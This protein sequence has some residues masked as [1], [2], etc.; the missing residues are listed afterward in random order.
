MTD[1]T[2][3]LADYK[4]HV[5]N[6]E[7]KVILVCRDRFKESG[8]TEDFYSE[9]WE[10]LPVKRPKHSN[11]KQQI[12]KPEELEQMIELAGVLSKAIP[13]VRVDFY[14]IDHRIYFGEITFFP[15]SGFRRFIPEEWDERFGEWIVLPK[16]T[17]K[18]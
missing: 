16:A 5:F 1:E 12:Q 7:T 6:G 18:N 13:F 8:L 4:L 17:E 10:H 11:A 15:A 9:K 3:E 2:E 14:I